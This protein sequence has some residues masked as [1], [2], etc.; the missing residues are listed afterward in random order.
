[1]AAFI[2]CDHVTLLWH[3]EKSKKEKPKT[4]WKA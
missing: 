2:S 1:M 4:N 3:V